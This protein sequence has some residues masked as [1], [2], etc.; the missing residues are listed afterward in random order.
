MEAKH[1]PQARKR[2]LPYNAD[3]AVGYQTAATSPGG[4]RGVADLYV[5]TRQAQRLVLG[6]A[7]TDDRPA[8][9]G[10]V[11]F[12]MMVRHLWGAAAGDDPYAD[13][14]LL[15][16]LENLE[17][18]REELERLE[19]DVEGLLQGIQGVDIS[20]AESQKPA[21]IPLQF[22]NPYGYMGAYLIS[23]YD[24]FA[25]AVLTA[26]HVG[27]LDRDSSERLLSK[28]GRLVRRAF[29][30]TQGYKHCAVTRDDMAAN[31]AR[32]RDAITAM[33][34]LP[35]DVLTGE[36][37]PRI[38]PEVRRS[39]AGWMASGETHGGSLDDL[40]AARKGKAPEPSGDRDQGSGAPDSEAGS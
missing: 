40:A 37:R 9:V 6:R 32:A 25:R 24:R 8:I 19:Q 17:Q 14:Y 20:V 38:A 35:Q 10:L 23:D 2:V 27:L 18:G 12:G 11:R 1:D 29:A 21:R 22:A 36:T 3:P 5:Q 33:G 13:W 7:A 4:L 30:S 15:Q 16:T 34:E 26:R 39:V 31:N 28:G